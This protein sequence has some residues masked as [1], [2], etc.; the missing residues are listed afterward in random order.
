MVTKNVFECPSDHV[1]QLRQVL[2][3]VSHLLIIGWRGADTH[4]LDF[5]RQ[6]RSEPLTRIHIVAGKKK[7]A[8][9]V[10]NHLQEDGAIRA[11]GVTRSAYGFSDFVSDDGQPER[12]EFLR[13]AG[14]AYTT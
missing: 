12:E 14:N 13:E 2:P 6:V 11:H 8:N 5:W 1:A 4:F 7:E 9:K 3:H 10:A